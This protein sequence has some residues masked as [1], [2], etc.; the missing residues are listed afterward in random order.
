MDD[1]IGVVM[2]TVMVCGIGR[3]LVHL[4]QHPLRA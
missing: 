4:C 3:L 1:M 2:V